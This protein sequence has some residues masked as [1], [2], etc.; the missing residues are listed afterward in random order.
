[1]NHFWA[2]IDRLNGAVSRNQAVNVNSVEIR[3]EAAHL[4][5]LWFREVRP[6]CIQSSLS[7]DELGVIDSSIQSLLRLSNGRNP[8]KSYLR[9][10]KSLRQARPALQA[11][12][13]LLE[14][15]TR[16]TSDQIVM[17]SLESGVIATLERMLPHAALSYRQVILDL[18]GPERL[19]YRGTATELREVVREVLDHLAPD[20]SV[21]S[22]P[23]FKLEKDRKVPTM[24]QKARFIL[25]ARGVGDSSRTAPEQSVELLEEQIAS[26]ARSVY[27]RGS[28]STHTATVKFQVLSFKAYADAVLGELLQLHV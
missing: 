5:Q 28:A 24:K 12:V 18:R 4:A 10:L 15:K 3:R 17:T 21:L 7:D 16:R 2:S 13:H 1:M 23:G 25:K 26:L 22:S 20:D 9:E 19:S 27:E 14:G 11:R 8:R 6:D